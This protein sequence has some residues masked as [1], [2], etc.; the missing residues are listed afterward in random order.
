MLPLQVILNEIIYKV[1]YLVS[2]HIEASVSRAVMKPSLPQ[3]KR[4]SKIC[5]SLPF[6]VGHCLYQSVKR[7]CSGYKMLCLR[8]HFQQQ[9]NSLVLK[10]FSLCVDLL[11]KSGYLIMQS[12]LYFHWREFLLCLLSA[13]ILYLDQYVC[14]APLLS[15]H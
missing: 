8:C 12:W 11:F 7:L 6:V 3:V 10:I 1:L 2:T 14:R 15:H 4:M 13:K 5:H 9:R